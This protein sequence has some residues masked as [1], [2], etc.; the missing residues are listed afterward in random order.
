MTETVV[1]RGSFQLVQVCAWDVKEYR[2]EETGRIEQDW[3]LYSQYNLDRLVELYLTEGDDLEGAELTEKEQ[4][5]V[6][7]F[8]LFL[9]KLVSRNVPAVNYEQLNRS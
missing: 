1:A 2:H 6:R 3:E 5:Q 8:A 9:K 4:A 7:D